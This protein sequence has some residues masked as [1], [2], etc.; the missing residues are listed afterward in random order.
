LGNDIDLG[1]QGPYLFRMLEE[2]K[3]ELLQ[4]IAEGA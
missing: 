2:H 1:A 3:G 4:E